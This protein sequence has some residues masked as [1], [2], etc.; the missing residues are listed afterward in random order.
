MT[1]QGESGP[2]AGIRVLDLT[3]L[4]PGPVCSLYLADF[5]ADVI[6]VEDTD[7]GD[8]SRRIGGN[9][10]TVSAFYR[11]INRNKRS[12]ALNLKDPR[13]RDAFL[14][15]A[16]TADV[17]VEG[18]RPGVM[19][20]LQLD[21]PILAEANPR[22]VY[23]SLSGYG[24]DGP[25]S[26]AAGHDINYLGYAGVLDQTGTRGGPPALSNLQIA[27]LLG[28]AATA[29]IG[30]LVALVGALRTGRGRYVD[31]AMAD[32]SFAHQILALCALEENGR[33]RARGDDLLTGGVPC[34][35]LYATSD[36]RYLAVG[37]L[38]EKFWRRLC[39]ALGRS[40]LIGSQFARDA[41]GESVRAALSDIFA[42][43]SLAEWISRLAGVDC[44]VTPV[45]TLEEALADP[46]FVARGM[47]VA[48]GGLRQFAPPFKT[49]DHTF[50]I[51]RPPPAQGADSV[52][53]L[54]EGGLPDATIN[55]LIA[56]RVVRADR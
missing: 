23:C 5:G 54:R 10:T 24:Q 26:H 19:A 32:A 29:A 31:V 55:E 4:L 16:R 17:I 13:G 9:S 53:V 22:I 14:T 27:D 49:S 20:S 30:I 12:L 21:Y 42:G 6:K 7:A 44:C 37:A 8:Y 56:A 39:E 18:F 28:G 52:A 11:L 2:L 38:E 1:A 48:S 3:R 50:V 51:G 25:R 45:L 36:G 34:Y 46:Q 41:A 35:G 43:A 40:D 47:V 33:L 15:L